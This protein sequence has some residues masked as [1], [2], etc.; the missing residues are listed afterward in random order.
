MTKANIDL[1]YQQ[2][3]YNKDLSAIA[4]E[5]G[6]PLLGTTLELIKTPYALVDRLYKTYGPVARSRILTQPYLMVS[7][8]DINQMIFLDSDKNF[9]AAMGYKESLAQFY[10]GGLLVRDF[11]DH[12]M[13]RRIFQTAFK[14]DTLSSYAEVMNGVMKKNIDCWGQQQDFHFFPAVKTTL[15]DVAAQIFLGI[16]DLNGNEAQR[17]ANTF[18]DISQGMMGLIHWDTPLLPFCKWRK[19]K[20]AKCYMEGYLISQIAERRLN[21]KSDIFSLICKERDENGDYF[22]DADIA[23]HIDFLLFAAHDTT[24]SNLSYI[25]QYLGQDKTLQDKA[26]AE[27]Q[28]KNKAFLAFDDLKD[29]H[30]L[31]KIHYEALRMHPSVMMLLRRTIRDCEI[32]GVHVPADTIINVFPQYTH[33]MEEY[34]QAPEKFDPERF[35]D[36]R[37]EHKRHPFAFIPFGGGA[38]KCI[39]LH[40]AGMLTKCF[41]HQMLLTYEWQ[42]PEGYAPEHQVFPMPKQKDDLPLQLKRIQH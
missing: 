33:R 30:E 27:C 35:S 1:S 15:L 19:G 32:A 41:M 39:G 38:H 20:Q 21:D 16:E 37:A 34:W 3:P 9:S 12:K 17:I 18:E 25:M 31:Q 26:R 24:T 40:F 8:A 13:H 11:D 22:S 6:L 10:S 29:M 7:G 28:A 42:V 5:D 14:N 23:S 36:E 4:G 2:R